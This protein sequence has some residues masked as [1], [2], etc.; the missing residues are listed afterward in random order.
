MNYQSLTKAELIKEIEKL[1]KVKKPKPRITRTKPARK[2][3]SILA[4]CDIE[5]DDLLVV[6]EEKRIAWVH[7]EVKIVPGKIR[8]HGYAVRSFKKGQVVRMHHWYDY[9]PS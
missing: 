8:I 1:K 7:P 3:D 2:P 9:E 5:K 6:D 4:G